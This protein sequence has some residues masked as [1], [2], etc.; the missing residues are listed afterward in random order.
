MILED[1][2]DCQL[3]IEIS[4]TKI[5]K[6][7]EIRYSQDLPVLQDSSD[8]LVDEGVNLCELN[9]INEA[10]VLNVLRKRFENFHIYNHCGAS[11][12]LIL[13][14]QIELPFVNKYHEV[15]NKFLE[16]NSYESPLRQAAINCY[17]NLERFVAWK[18]CN[19]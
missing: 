19:F 3:W 2:E 17:R 13:N 14:P 8:D 7:L 15:K 16:E 4:S 9:R 11:T 5:K 10:S 6:K 18:L 1:Y 12:M